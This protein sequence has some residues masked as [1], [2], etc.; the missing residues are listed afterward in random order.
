M[1]REAKFEDLAAI[2]ALL[3]DDAVHGFREAPGEP[4][5]SGY[6][7]AFGAIARDPNNVL[8]V[9][10]R[11]GRIVATGQITFVPSL[12]QKG[13]TRAIIEAV[14]VAS[15]LRSQGIGE[16]LIGYLEGL[17]RERGC[18]AMQLTTSHKRSDAHRFYERIGY[19]HY[20]RGYKKD[21]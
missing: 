7:A 2:V 12:V 1:F 18:I 5:A 9:G 15:G 10:E 4:L 16:E 14:R 20:H 6:L 13:A 11:D 17:A 19:A 3:A 8:V 21:L